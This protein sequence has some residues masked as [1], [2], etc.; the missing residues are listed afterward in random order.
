MPTL[1]VAFASTA[2]RM[3]SS[4]HS[5]L[6]RPAFPFFCCSDSQALSFVCMHNLFSVWPGLCSPFLVCILNLAGSI[7]LVSFQVVVLFVMCRLSCGRD[8]IYFCKTSPSHQEQK[9]ANFSFAETM[10]S[11]PFL[12]AVL[13]ALAL[14]F[15]FTASQGIPCLHE[16]VHR[17]CVDWTWEAREEWQHLDIACLRIKITLQI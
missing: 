7:F 9:Q 14:S 12:C 15:P 3:C 5:F 6:K 8:E 10:L 1:E 4:F 2:T 11:G 16:N 13:G 17:L